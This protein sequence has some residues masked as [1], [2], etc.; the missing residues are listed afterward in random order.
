MDDLANIAKETGAKVLEIE[1]ML[2]NTKLKNHLIKHYHFTP[3]DHNWD[4]ISIGTTDNFAVGKAM[5]FDLYKNVKN[6]EKITI[7]LK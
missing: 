6:W 4:T 5:G 7:Q 3:G 1:G 2:H